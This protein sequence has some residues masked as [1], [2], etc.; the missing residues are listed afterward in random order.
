MAVQTEYM[1]SGRGTERCRQQEEAPS[2]PPTSSS[3]V[4]QEEQECTHGTHKQMQDTCLMLGTA[5][6]LHLPGSR[7]QD[8][9]EQPPVSQAQKENNNS[10][11][12]TSSSQSL[13]ITTPLPNG[14]EGRRDRG[15]AQR[16]SLKVGEGTEWRAS[17]KQE[18]ASGMVEGR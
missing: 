18:T 7:I 14:R 15:M 6:F 10:R 3:H 16:V 5:E 12:T 2:A 17:Q 9:A 13:C 1:N 8:K 4:F 11:S